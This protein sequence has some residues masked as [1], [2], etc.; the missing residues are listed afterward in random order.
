MNCT[1]RHFL[2]TLILLSGT[3]HAQQQSVPDESV[4]KLQTTTLVSTRTERS[5]LESPASIVSI[6][7]THDETGLSEDA[8]NLVSQTPGVSIPFDYRGVDALIPYMNGGYKSYNIRGVEGNRVLLE[9]DGIRQVPEYSEYI[10]GGSGGTS[11]AMFDPKVLESVDILKGSASALYGSDALGGVVSMKTF[12]LIDYLEVSEKPYYLEGSFSYYSVNEGF[13][14]AVKAGVRSGNFYASIVNSYRTSSE[15][16]ND[17]GVD[18]YPEE[19]TSNHVL[20]TIALVPSDAH[21]FTLIAENYVSDS[22][23]DMTGIVYEMSMGGMP[24][25]IDYSE[26]ASSEA[27]S[28][29]DRLSLKYENK[30]ATGLWDTLDAHLYYQKTSTDLYTHTVGTS[31]FAPDS[32]YPGYRPSPRNRLDSMGFSH[33]TVGLSVLAA[34]QFISESVEQQL[35]TG[36]EFSNEE[37]ENTF[38]REDHTTDPITYTNRMSTDPSTLNR[39]DVFAQDEIDF[40]KT[41]L[42]AGLRYAHYEI[43]PDND[44]R[45]L[46]ANPDVSAS[47][48]YSNDTL[49]PSLSLVYSLTEDSVLWG[50]YARGIKNPTNENYTGA[51]S[52][53]GGTDPFIIVANPDLDPEKSDAFEFSYRK[54]SENF[55]FDISAHKTYYEDFIDSSVLIEDNLPPEPD[56]Y[57]H[58]N[59]E[60]VEIQGVELSFQYQLKAISES[61]DGFSLQLSSAWTDGENKTDDLELGT[62]SPF[63]TVINLSYRSENRWGGTLSGTYRAK[64]SNAGEL[65]EQGYFVPDSSF[66]LDAY[67]YWNLSDH[68]SIRG[69]VRNLTDETYWIWSNSSRGGHSSGSTERNVQPGINAYLTLNLT[70]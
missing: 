53:S 3:M 13:N 48:D 60:E 50:R 68:V 36:I 9:I 19:N 17:K 8:G 37:T 26:H 65:E 67:A 24:Y 31:G 34:K 33:E 52:H 66:V 32:M 57:S 44:S 27:E 12:S 21:R 49:T 62:I 63:E 40:G 11:R 64:R 47:E 16:Q 7:L 1:K 51:F 41:L 45:Y 10:G 18:P 23:T 20:A 56:L 6:D 46:E 22:E 61:L 5:M 14:Q 58:E 28:Q 69:G 2:L 15:Q 38:V 59:V 42:I 70:L 4:P 43:N 25:A 39:F 54:Y 55:Q 30:S 29:R 35:I